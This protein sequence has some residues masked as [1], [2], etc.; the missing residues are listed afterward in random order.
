M[1]FRLC[2][3]LPGGHRDLCVL[4]IDPSVLDI[5]G[6]LVTAENAA[7]GYARFYSARE[8]LQYVDREMTF[9]E[10]WTDPDPIVQS[11]KK[12]ARCAEILIPDLVPT[13]YIMGAYTSCEATIRA[14]AEAGLPAATLNAHIFFC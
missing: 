1:M 12:A 6:A 14:V 2:Q 8:G 5:P 9:A 3:E 7:C 11:H 10:W 13:R 4:R